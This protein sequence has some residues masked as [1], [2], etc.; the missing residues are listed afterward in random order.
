MLVNTTRGA[1]LCVACVI[2][3]AAM[4]IAIIVAPAVANR[5]TSKRATPSTSA[6][7]TTGMSQAA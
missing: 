6:I 3:A 2:A 1:S 7:P 4:T 5:D